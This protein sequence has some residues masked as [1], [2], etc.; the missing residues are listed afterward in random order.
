MT[1]SSAYYDFQSLS[2]LRAEAAQAPNQA[3]KEVASQFESL[4]MQMMVKSMREATI[5]GGLFES[6]QMDL[7]QSMLDQQVSMQL[8]SQG[9][10]GLADIL[11]Q[12]LDS[13]AGTAATAEESASTSGGAAT[14][15]S[16]ADYASRIRAA[17]PAAD[18]SPLNNS[19]THSAVHSKTNPVTVPGPI[20]AVSQTSPSSHWNPETVEDYVDAVWDHAV[21]AAREIGVD[22]KVLVAQSALETGWGKRMIKAFDGGNSFNLFGIKA[23]NGWQGQQ[24]AVDTLEFRDGVAAK[25][26]ANFRVYDSVAS[27]FNDYVSF[28]KSNPRYQEALEKVADAREFLQGLQDAGYA[29]DP[30]YSQKIMKIIHAPALSSALEQLKK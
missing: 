14:V 27:S 26:Q 18:T 15:T 4:F 17:M 23:G 20:A 12:Q 5:K 21:V 11:V 13:N 10:M 16:L 8:S 9:G 3:V 1:A 28:L 2:A 24:A 7:Y 19:A 29:T 6:N 22:P 25:E 30:N